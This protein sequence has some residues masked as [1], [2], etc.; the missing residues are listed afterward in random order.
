[1]F[2]DLFRSA[3]VRRRMAASHLGIILCDFVVALHAR[4]HT[5]QCIQIYGQIAEHFSR[6]LAKER[7]QPH[8]INE[9]VVG[10]FL[11]QHLQCCR[12]PRPAPVD[13]KNCRAALGR[14][15]V[16]LR[17]RRLIT[18]RVAEPPS[19]SGRLV[20]DYDF[21]ARDVQGL[22]ATTRQYLRRYAREF[23]SSRQ[24][25]GPIRLAD[26]KPRD[27]LK[28][29]QHRARHLKPASVRVL[30]GALRGFLRFLH[31]TGRIDQRLVHAVPC[32]APWPR[33]Q[34]PVTLSED[35]HAAFLRSFDR[36]TAAGRRDFAMAQF[37]C[38][39]GLRVNEVAALTL[40]DVDWR[41]RTV[42]LRQTKQRRERLLPLP[43]VALRALLAYLRH[44]RPPTASRALFVRHR[45]PLGDA[46]RM[47][48]VRSAMR[49]AFAR[50]G[51]ASSRTHLLRHTFATRLHRRHVDLKAI[52]D[53]L[54]HRSL[55]T[56]A[57]YA[58]IDLAELRQ[59][60]LP[61]PE[62]WR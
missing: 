20:Q 14:L 24:A 11:K 10:R 30:V 41:R 59:A 57:C 49:R 18:E 56:T 55:N 19:I 35:Q 40:E 12:C 36:S 26:L 3:L 50:S 29:V 51:I 54:G 45:A 28:Y 9:S 62:G 39:L 6:W 21:H 2:E 43:S 46:L 23:L 15:L 38:R 1:M 7:L 37:L 33:S 25:Q 8:E 16:F 4:G 60:A 52:A 5:R 34:L 32:P 44:G 53:L 47:E 27:L 58:R 17:E 48:H 13:A 22:A 61:W 42:R 31:L